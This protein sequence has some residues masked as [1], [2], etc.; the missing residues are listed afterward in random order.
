MPPFRFGAVEAFAPSGRDWKALAGQVEDRGFSTLQIVDHLGPMFAPI[1]ALTAAADA[2]TT[3][4]VGAQVFSNDYRHP[5]MLAKECAT[6]DLLSGGRLELGLGAGWNVTDYDAMGIEFD[7]PSVRIDR[8]EESL[9]IVRSC[10]AD[11]QFSFTGTYYSVTDYEGLPKPAQRPGP[12]L[13]VG[14]GGR[15]MLGVAGRYADIVGL[16]F[17][18]RAGGERNP[19]GPLVGGIM[20]P[21]IAKTG[22]AAM[23]EQKIGWLRDSAGSRFDELELNITA[24]LTV[25]TD[26]PED[27]AAEMA[28]QLGIS[29]ADILELPFA[30]IGPVERIIDLLLERRERYGISYVSFPMPIIPNGFEVLAPVIARLAGT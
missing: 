6:L 14:G 30:L 29:P 22:T 23:V 24:F 10:F 8:L 26:A 9:T 11:Q 1:S 19:T 5:V 16:N 12:P 20:T 4:R 17:D 15:R 2:T 28:S 25:V 13:L 3:L 18:L 27:V 7:S 21:E